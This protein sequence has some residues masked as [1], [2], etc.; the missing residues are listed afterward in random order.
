MSYI[1]SKTIMAPKRKRTAEE[2]QLMIKNAKISDFPSEEK[3][4]EI[5]NF[6]KKC[7]TELIETQNTLRV[8][9]ANWFAFEFMAKY[10]GEYV[11]CKEVQEHC[12]LRNKEVKGEILGDPPRAF[13]LCRKNVMPLDWS[14]VQVGRYKLVRYTPEKRQNATESIVEQTKHR[15]D[16]FTSSLIKKKLEECGYKCEIT[17][18]PMSDGKLAADHFQPKEQ[19]GQSIESNCVILNKILNEKKSNHEPIEWFCKTLLTNFLVICK[20]VGGTEMLESCKSRI[21]SF[22]NSFE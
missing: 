1:V 21:I 5:E 12:S 20:R 4:G 3:G 22:V 6:K 9:S 19:G 18:L 7:Y 10:P 17:G 14:E 15:N 16:G 8:N 11:L 13:E 2:L